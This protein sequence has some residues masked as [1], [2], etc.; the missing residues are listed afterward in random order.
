[1]NFYFLICYYRECFYRFHKLILIKFWFNL[2]ILLAL[3]DLEIF[4]K[5]LI[6]FSHFY[7]LFII[8]IDE[9]TFF[10]NLSF[11]CFVGCIKN[12]KLSDSCNHF[13]MFFFKNNFFF[14]TILFQVF[15]YKPQIMQHHQIYNDIIFLKFL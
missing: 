7:C 11:K 5:F 6:E 3:L 9:F 2:F 13:L 4:F 10:C 14:I 1:V 12:Y 8:L 15:A